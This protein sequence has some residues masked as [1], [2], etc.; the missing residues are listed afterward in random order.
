MP[1]E[2]IL[3]FAIAL[4]ISLIVTPVV[5][6]SATRLK[7]LDVPGG[8]KIHPSPVPSV[9]GMAIYVSIALTSV[10]AILLNDRIRIS[11]DLNARFWIAIGIAAT[12]VFLVGL[13]DDIR[14]ASIWVRF[15]FQTIAAL[16]TIFLGGVVIGAVGIPHSGLQSTGWFAVPLTVLWIVGV[17]NAFNLIDGLDGLA[18]GLGFISTAAVFT[19][20]VMTTRNYMVMLVSAALCGAIAGFLKYNRAP[21]KIFLGDCGSMLLGY[22]LSVLA[23]LGRTK[24]TTIL[25]ILVPVLIV[26]VPVLDTLSSMVRR[27]LHKLLIEKKFRISY[28]RSMFTGDRGHIH[29]MLLGMGHTQRLSVII[30]YA[31]SFVLAIF[32]LIATIVNEEEFGFILL[33]FGVGAFFVVRQGWHRFFGKN[34]RGKDGPI[35]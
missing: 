20:T 7:L 1:I 32:A 25:A 6:R 3:A 14:R 9:G 28:L 17:T 15:S 31:L 4:L 18:G 24:K 35:L 2:A 11:F 23:I 21:A 16:I 34:G 33:L 8:L 19:I 27:L 12:I 5:I 29:H 10:F 30:L 22:S 26:G 13:Y